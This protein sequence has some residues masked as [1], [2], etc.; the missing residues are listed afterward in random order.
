MN[1]LIVLT[2]LNTL[3]LGRDL[4]KNSSSQHGPYL[5][6]FNFTFYNIF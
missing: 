5:A 1:K 4:T 6:D 2:T 3:I